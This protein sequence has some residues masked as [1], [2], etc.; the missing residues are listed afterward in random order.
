MKI[1]IAYDGSSCGDAALDDL[2]RAGLPQVA[3]VLVLSVADVW[4]D[5]YAG[6]DILGMVTSSIVKSK[7]DETYELAQGAADR[8][9]K[10]HPGWEIVAIEDTGSPAGKILE[11]ADQFKPDL[12]VA[13]SHGL[14]TLKRAILGSVS[15]RVVTEAHCSVRV[16]RGRIDED[17]P[18]VRIVIGVDGSPDSDLAVERVASRKWLPDSMVHLVTSIGVDLEAQSSSDMKEYFVSIEQMQH[19]YSARLLESGL[20]VTTHI[21]FEDPRHAIIHEA[22]KWGADSI[23]LGS[24]GLGKIGRMLQGSVSAAVTSRAHCSVEV[25]R[26]SS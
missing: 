17:Q 8:L 1:L 5:N 14:S 7:K 2:L 21:S 3:E 19:Q 15:Q 20:R 22:E 25:V 26:P 6:K 16:A 23:F 10:E 12:I 24:C 9:R 18:P 4:L 13:G 11:H